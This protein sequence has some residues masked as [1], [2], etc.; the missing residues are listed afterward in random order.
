MCSRVSAMIAARLTGVCAGQQRVQ[1]AEELVDATFVHGEQELVLAREIEVDG[2]LGEPG[3]VGDL[4]DV[5]DT[6]RRAREQPLGGVENRVVA[7]LLVFRVD[8]ALPD[9][10]VALPRP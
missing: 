1:R 3:L 8:S 10:H 2:A 7:L 6:L 9:H 5:G 4:R